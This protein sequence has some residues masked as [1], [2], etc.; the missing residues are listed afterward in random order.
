MFFSQRDN[1]LFF[2]QNQ[3]WYAAI[4]LIKIIMINILKKT[5]IIIIIKKNIK[6]KNNKNLIALTAYH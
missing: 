4:K 3:I 6:V 2:F 1:I 5:M